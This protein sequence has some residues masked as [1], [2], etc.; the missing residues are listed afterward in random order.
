M[1]KAYVLENKQDS[2][3]DAERPV[4]LSREGKRTKLN[5]ELI[6]I[7]AVETQSNKSKKNFLTG[8]M[9]FPWFRENKQTPWGF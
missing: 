8:H 1:G 9:K 7:G 5:R 2:F 3:G 6:A 4:F